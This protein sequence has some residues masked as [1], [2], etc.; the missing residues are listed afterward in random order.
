VISVAILTISDSAM[1]GKREDVSGPAL[2]HRCL[3][4]K[5]QVAVTQ[6]VADDEQVIRFTLADWADREMADV[7]LTTGGTGISPTD[8]TPEATRAVLDREVP[9]VAELL[10]SKGLEQT[11]FSVLSRALA[12]SRK[13]SFILN[14]PGSPKGAVFSLGLVEGLIPHV[15]DLL[16]GRTGH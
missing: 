15:V 2:K 6:L 5:W 13:Q 12:G 16:H 1:A 7:I 11:K 3:E 8:V 4:L 9:G 10:R 14:L